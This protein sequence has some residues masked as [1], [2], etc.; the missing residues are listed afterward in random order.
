M[1][2]VFIEIRDAVKTALAPSL[3]LSRL[4]ERGRTIARRLRQTPRR[5]KMQNSK[6]R[7]IFCPR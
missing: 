3:P 5:R 1:W 7:R 6:L 4:L 2:P